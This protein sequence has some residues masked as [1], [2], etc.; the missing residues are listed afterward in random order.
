[1][2]RFAERTKHEISIQG[3][4]SAIPLEIAPFFDSRTPNMRVLVSAAAA[5]PFLPYPGVYACSC[6]NARRHPTWILS[7]LHQGGCRS[8]RRFGFVILPWVSLYVH[9][10]P[11]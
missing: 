1:M 7:F 6:K 8:R 11:A 2:G 9:E 4:V 3:L 5:G 10:Q